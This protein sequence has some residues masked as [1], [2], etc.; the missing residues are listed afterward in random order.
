MPRQNKTGQ[1]WLN[2]INTRLRLDLKIANKINTR[3]TLSDHCIFLEWLV[4]LHSLSQPRYIQLQIC[5][6][7]PCHGMSLD[8]GREK[9]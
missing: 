3:E 7:Y 1:G 9:G 5:Y 6:S 8:T 4:S 2:M